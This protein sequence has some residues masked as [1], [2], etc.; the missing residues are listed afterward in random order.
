[1]NFL[2]KNLINFILAATIG[3]PFSIYG[4]NHQTGFTTIEP[5]IEP[6]TTQIVT[7]I[8]PEFEINTKVDCPE[9]IQ[10][11]I[12]EVSTEYH[13]QFELMLALIE[14]ES[15]FQTDIIS[16]TNDYGLCQINECRLESLKKQG[17]TDIM[18]VRQNV[19]ASCMI[20]SGLFEKYEDAL[21]VLMAYNFG[22]AGAKKYWNNGIYESRYSIKIMNRKGELEHE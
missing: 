15:D 18:D 6:V 10:R 2:R 8:E 4:I 7:E 1:M 12:W 22:E 3:I 14:T 11:I 9:N 13:I 21:C 16:D 20:L 19:T 5:K 17:I